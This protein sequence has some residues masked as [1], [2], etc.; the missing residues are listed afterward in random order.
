MGV[1][2]GGWCSNRTRDPHGVSLLKHIRAGWDR[3][4]H[5]VSFKVGDGSRIKFWHDFWCGDQP[6]RDKFPGLFR[7]ARNQEATVA[8]SLRFQGNTHSWDIEFL[9]QAQDWEMDI[10]DTF[11]R[12]LYSSPIHSGR[13]DTIGWNLGSRETFEVRSFYSALIQPSY[14]YFPWRSVWKAKVP[15]RVAFFL[16]TAALGKILTTD[17][18]QKRR[19]T[20][21]DWCCMCKADGESVNHLLLHCPVARDL[22][23][24]IFSL[25]G[26]SWVMPR[27]VVDLI[28]CWNGCKGRQEAGKIWKVIPHCIM[29]CLWC[30]RNARSFNGEEASIPALK[31][32]LLQTMLE[33]LK[34][35]SLI[36]SV[37]IPEML[38]LCSF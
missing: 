37:S 30:E 32:R 20:I 2:G 12:W 6:L 22:W 8:D 19:V 1:N 4:S 10:V 18:L 31:H 14:S 13:M 38:M 35:A 3:F 29:W 16:W 27:G 33:W 5:Y 9:R 36:T 28:S 21:L 7:L 17:N 11:M 15:S 26:I 25:F 23:N 24:M 34:A